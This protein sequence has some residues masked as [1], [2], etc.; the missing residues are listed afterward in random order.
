[1]V[2]K[3]IT[4]TV[5]LAIGFLAAESTPAGGGLITVTSVF[6]EARATIDGVDSFAYLLP[7]V[8][9]TSSVTQAQDNNYAFASVMS[10]FSDTHIG[11]DALADTDH[12]NQTGS[13]GALVEINFT[14]H[15]WVTYTRFTDYSGNGSVALKQN[16][17]TL[18]YDHWPENSCEDFGTI[19]DDCFVLGP[20]DYTLGMSGW[21][22]GSSCGGCFVEGSGTATLEFT[23]CPDVD[24]DDVCAFSDNCPDVAN[25]IQLD[26]DGD[27]LGDA[28]DICVG[29]IN[30]DDL[31]GLCEDVD[32][33]PGIPNPTQAD[34]DNDDSGDAC[35]N[36]P[37]Y[38]NADQLDTDGDGYGDECDNCPALHNPWQIDGDNDGVGLQCDN[39]PGDSNGSQA[40]NDSDGHGNPCDCAHNDPLIVPALDVPGMTSQKMPAAIRLNWPAS[41]GAT[42][43]AVIR[44]TISGLSAGLYGSCMDNNLPGPEYDD[45]TL[46]LAGDPFIYL[47]RGSNPDCGDGTLGFESTGAERAAVGAIPCP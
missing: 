38:R 40:D 14:V 26:S 3:P 4:L 35:D 15:D 9:D 39:C 7:T 37:D 30:D 23:A 36:C 28:C 29:P 10:D 19:S 17:L 8:P 6:G 22:L 2:M 21:G 1:M 46:P 13:A 27:G 25:P 43:Y 20:G 24:Q 12:V 41:P 18:W 31:D 5:L 44:G 47:I 34:Q 11:G 45:P 33:C 32:N 42:S 16:G